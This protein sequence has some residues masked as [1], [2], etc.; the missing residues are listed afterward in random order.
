VAAV[1]AYLVMVGLDD[2]DKISSAGAFVVALLALVAP[3]LLPPPSPQ[4][5]PPSTEPE[6]ESVSDS[7]ID[8]RHAQGVQVNQSGGNTQT[9]NFGNSA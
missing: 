6:G 5:G 1:V 8:L 2:A 9:N 4:P 7:R 3:Y